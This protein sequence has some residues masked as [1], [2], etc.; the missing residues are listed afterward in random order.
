METTDSRIKRNVMRRVHAV[1]TMRL[2]ASIT[3]PLLVLVASLYGIGRE[4]WVARVFANMPSLADVSAVISFFA[5]AFASTHL[6]VQLLILLSIA[7]T[8]WVL[9]EIYHV[10][11]FPHHRYA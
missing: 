3:L 4:V 1:H 7:A 8:F 11:Q 9:R 5:S 10:L 6:A 2:A